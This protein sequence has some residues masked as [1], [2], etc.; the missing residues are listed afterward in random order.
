MTG[1]DARRRAG[2]GGAV[3]V[4]ASASLPGPLWAWAGLLV[5]VSVAIARLISN[6]DD[7]T[8]PGTFAVAIRVAAPIAMAGLAGLW[9]ERSGTVNIG[10]EGMMTAG[11]VFGGWFAWQHGPWFGLLGGVVGGL[12]GGLL[13]GLA[14]VTFGVNHIVA[15]FAVNILAPG[16]ARFM[17]NVLFVGEQGGSLTNSPGV[18]GKMGEFTLPFLS[19]GR[20]LA[21]GTPDPLA[22][23]ASWRW[24]GVSDVGGFLSG[25]TTGISYDVLLAIGLFVLSGYVLWHTP[26]GLRLR[27]AGERPSAADS[28]GV[29]VHLYRYIGVAI[30]GALAGIGGAMLVLLSGRYSQDMVAGRGFLGLATVVVGNWRPFGVGAA[31]LMFGY[32]DGLTLRLNPESL[33]LAVVLAAALML[34][35]G[36]VYVATTRRYGLV[37]LLALPAGALG[38]LG[39][40]YGLA[41]HLQQNGWLLL[42]L[43]VVG[44]GVL[45]IVALVVAR[46]SGTLSGTIMAMAAAAAVFA[47][48]RLDDLPSEF[49]AML[50][51]AVT[52]IVVA[53]RG[54]S[55]RPPAQAGEPWFKGQN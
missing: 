27:S 44:G 35:V 39:V 20:F 38:V 43:W 40:L 24:F 4:A 30:S 11:T 9:S 42:S 48:V 47:Y 32:F 49:V 26:F 50:P 22:R 15:G 23:I 13:L 10:L 1:G 54:Q 55:L 18:S 25:V 3:A 6:T 52:L 33:L 53:S 29:N 36:L 37:R 46:R 5:V 8:S 41:E 14:T 31:A 21:W 45:A 19:G 16:V 7:V 51:Y 17:A 34:L 12:L 28:L 2:P